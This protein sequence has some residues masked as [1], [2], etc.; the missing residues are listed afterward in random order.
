[1]SFIELHVVDSRSNDSV[2]CAVCHQT[3]HMNCVRPPLLK[4]PSRGFAW[5]CGP[6]SRAQERKLEARNT[7][8]LADLGA[9]P[10]EEE[11]FDE[12]DE[13]YLLQGDES[14]TGRTSPARSVDGDL[15][16]HPG[17]PEQIYQASLWPYRYLGVHCRVEDAL[18]YDDRIYPRASS[19]LGPRHQ[20]NV[21]VWH[22]RPVE[23]VKA[24]EIK[25]KYVKGGTHKKDAKL[26]KETLAAIEADKI[27]RERRPKWVIDEPPGYVPRGEDFA[28]DD[29]KNTAQLLFKLPETHDQSPV[30]EQSGGV[31]PSASARSP[32]EVVDDYMVRAKEFAGVIGVPEYSVNFIDK[33][34]TIY[35]SVNYD[36]EAALRELSKVQKKDL[37]EPELTP[38]EVKKFEDGVT[39]FGSEL[40]SVK[41]HVKTVSPADI[42]RFYYVWKKSER[43]KQIWGNYSGRKGKKEAK[44]V[45]TNALKLQDDVADDHD[46]SAFDNDKAA[47]KKRGF[48][49]KFCSTRSSRQW[50]RAPNTAPGTTISADANSKGAGKDKG[51]QLMV[52]LCLNCAVV[53]RKYAVQWEEGEDGKKSGPNGGRVGKRKGDDALTEFQLNESSWTANNTDAPNTPSAGTPVPQAISLSTAQEPAR[54]KAKS[55]IDKDPIDPGAESSSAMQSKKKVVEKVTGPPPA[56]EVPRPKTL[57]CAVCLQ[58]EPLDADQRLSCKECRMTVHRNCYG[59]VGE[60]RGA[61]KWICDMCSNDRNPQVSVVSYLPQSRTT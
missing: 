37:K 14:G 56:P 52:A 48:Q 58:M 21:T 35:R 43:G 16:V 40:H 27:A 23:L 51:P 25:R 59:V 20:A 30:N 57:P 4:K 19:R 29:P 50:R 6:C 61:G 5:A 15:S 45:E 28:N 24:A 7:P 12:E 54:K 55:S 10:E 11:V 42:V 46:D 2:D 18:D 9:D 38:A 31:G 49:C 36:A 17:T 41:K 26:S 32:E 39:R 1:M 47:E 33:A 34:L 44:K 53:W 13:D 3:Y 8:N 22:G 60:T